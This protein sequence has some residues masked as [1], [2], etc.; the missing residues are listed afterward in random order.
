MDTKPPKRDENASRLLA[1]LVTADF[2]K[3]NISRSSLAHQTHIPRETLRRKM[4][5]G[6]F[7]VPELYKIAPLIGGDPLVWIARVDSAMAKDSAA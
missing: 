4:S 2:T 5:R 6:D 3:S 1:E 7:T